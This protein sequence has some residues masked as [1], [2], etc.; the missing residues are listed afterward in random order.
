MPNEILKLSDIA[1]FLKARGSEMTL[2]R[3]KDGW[4]MITVNA[5]VQ[6]HRNGFAIPQYFPDLAAVEKRYKTWRGILQLV[7]AEE[8]ETESTIATC[9]ECGCNDNRACWDEVA[10]Q[11]CA[12]LVV[13]RAAGL[14]VCTACPDAVPRW[15]RGDRTIS[16]PVDPTDHSYSH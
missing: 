10:D 8:N 1:Y 16:V 9:I 3:V 7:A 13:D 4:E 2:T 6:A 14:G 15:Q 12:W 5:A 11:P